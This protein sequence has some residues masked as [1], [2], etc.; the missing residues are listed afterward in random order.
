MIV[1]RGPDTAG[2]KHDVARGKRAF[3]GRFNPQ[4]RIAYIFGVIKLLA[5][6]I[7]QFNGFGQVFVGAFARQD[8]VT[9]LER[10]V[11]VRSTA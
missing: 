6:L 3:Q 4:G 5:P 9:N 7:Q 8:F 11:L 2:G 1:W 10:P